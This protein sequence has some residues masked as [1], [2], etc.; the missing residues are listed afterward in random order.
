[1]AFGSP[2]PTPPPNRYRAA[3]IGFAALSAVLLTFVGYRAVA[4]PAALETARSE[5]VELLTVQK[6]A[7]NAGD[8]GRF[9]ATYRMHDDLTF[10]SD[11]RR[12]Q[13][14]DKLVDRYRAMYPGGAKGQIDYQNVTAEPLAAD[15]VLLRGAWVLASAEGT[16][17]GLFTILARKFPLPEGWKIVHDHITI[18][19]MR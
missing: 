12:Y 17:Q 4:A 7:W 11:G 16:R 2:T 14:W 5:A 18:G 10:F 13:G 15:A 9:T 3:C 8:L 6:S 19:E 1:M